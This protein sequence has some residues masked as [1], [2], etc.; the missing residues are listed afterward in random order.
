MV[1]A[2]HFGLA[3]VWAR[4]SQTKEEDNQV[5]SIVRCLKRL[6]DR[7]KRLDM[8]P[9]GRLLLRIDRFFLYQK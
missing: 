3:A 8:T 7:V 4:F 9:K 2:L 5:Y 6:A 1:V